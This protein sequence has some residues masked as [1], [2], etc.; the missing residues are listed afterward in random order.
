MSLPKWI[1]ESDAIYCSERESIRL[2]KQA[3][4]I[5]H[6]ALESVDINFGIP[7]YEKERPS[8][9]VCISEHKKVQEALRRIASLGDTEPEYTVEQVGSHKYKIEKIKKPGDTQQGEEGK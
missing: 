6:Q 4:S 2:L 8:Y 9:E 1:E 3:L 7:I 5:A